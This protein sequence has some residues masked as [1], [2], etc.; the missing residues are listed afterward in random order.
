MENESS[1][2]LTYLQ[3][4]SLLNKTPEEQE[5]IKKLFED[6]KNLAY[7]LASKY[8][9]TH[10]WDFD[11]SLQIA[12]LGLFKACLIWDPSKYRLT[13]LAYNIMNRDFIDYDKQQK[14]QP[15]IILSLDEEIKTAEELVIGD[16]IMDDR[17]NQEEEY[18]QNDSVT[19]LNQDII[20][21]LEDIA[22]ELGISKSATKLI[23]LTY[24]ESSK[25][26]LISMR[27]LNFIKKSV[28]NEVI[29]RLK[30]KLHNL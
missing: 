8:Y 26:N 18:V 29:L 27:Q 15:D 4:I 11:D 2:K 21:I 19:E 9:K 22:E 10:Y 1:K 3:K 20:Y 14:R 12:Q 25:D 24:M 6:N 30:E 17:S 28:V 7:K 23:Y 13:T 5:R 16:M